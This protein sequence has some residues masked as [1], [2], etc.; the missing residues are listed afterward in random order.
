MKKKTQYQDKATIYFGDCL[1]IL[2]KIKDESVD[3]I[4]TDPP[5]E[6]GKSII[7]RKNAKDLNS[8]FG[9]W[10]KFFTE[11]IIKSYRLLKPDSGMVIFVPATRYETLWNACYKSG[12]EPVQPW[13]FHKTNPPVSIRRGLQWAVEHMMYVVKGKHHLRI[14][15]KGKCHNVFSYPSAKKDRFHPTQKPVELM[16]DIIRYVSDEG[17]TILDPFH[18]SGSTGIAALGMDRKY[19]GIEKNEE[20][21]KNSLKRFDSFFQD[22]FV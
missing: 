5:Y 7:T 16:M 1:K 3:F 22:V 17:Q 12:F 8:D 18:G 2:P 13:F 4:V 19:I 10:D 21:Y 20:Y 14:E 15:N 6:A 11:W 9:E